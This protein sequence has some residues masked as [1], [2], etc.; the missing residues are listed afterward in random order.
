MKRL[1]TSVDSYLCKTLN[2]H[3]QIPAVLRKKEKKTHNQ[4]ETYHSKQITPTCLE[5]QSE[6]RQEQSFFCVVRH[7]WVPWKALQT[8]FII[9]IITGILAS[10]IHLNA[11]LHVALIFCLFLG[12]FS[13]RSIICHGFVGL[14]FVV[15]VPSA[16]YRTD[17][18]TEAHQSV[19]T[20]NYLLIRPGGLF[21]YYFSNL[22]YFPCS[23]HYTNQS[24]SWFT[25]LFNYFPLY[26]HRL[27]LSKIV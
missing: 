2:I 1:Q 12:L 18:R 10:K 3:I 21:R 26:L 23:G 15:L 4:A 8:K 27:L 17:Q 25:S 16:C 24:W 20:E 11:L 19:F 5:T 9:I 13:H 6:T 14:T 22:H 7:P